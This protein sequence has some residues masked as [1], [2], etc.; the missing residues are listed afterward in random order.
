MPA[1]APQRSRR[2]HEEIVARIERMIAE[3][4]VRT[5]DRLPPERR[6]AEIFRVSRHSLREAIRAMEQKGLLRSHIGDGT[7][8]LAGSEREFVEPLA[9][10]VVLGQDQLREIFELRRLLEPQVAARAAEAAGAGDLARLRA[11]WEK[12]KISPPAKA[13]RM[14]HAFH[15]QIARATGNAVLLRVFEQLHAIL[16]ESRAES[17]QSET[18]RQASIRTHGRILQALEQRDAERA[19]KEMLAHLEQIE[20]T[21]FAP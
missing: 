12:Q 14:D 9:R 10:A 2:L 11:L 19:R 4:E 21:V 17:L 18:R 5:G 13:V 1:S 6:L 15:L 20:K 3:G 16:G 8:V 7:Y